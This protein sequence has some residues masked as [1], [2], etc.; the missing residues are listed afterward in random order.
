MLTVSTLDEIKLFL[1]QNVCS[2]HKLKKPNDKNVD[3][4]ELVNPNVFIM[5]FPPKNFL[6][7]GIKSTIPCIMINFED[8]IDDNQTSDMNVRLIFIVY[9][10]GFHKENS[11]NIVEVTPD[12]NGWIDLLNF[13]DKT[14]A[15]ILR[16]RIL[17]GITIQSP[18]KWGIYQK[19]EQIPDTDPYFYG[20]ITFGTQN[21]AYPASQI[22]KLLE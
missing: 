5:N 7:D 13:I 17:N 10:P 15:E 12:G 8:G 11:E 2:K 22:D 20:W 21:K 3:E 19:E 14:K 4:F 9:N 16:N 1:Q 18:L 6:P